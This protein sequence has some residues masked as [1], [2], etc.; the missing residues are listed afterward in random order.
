MPT[1]PQG[2]S[3]IPPDRGA[4]VSEYREVSEG[5]TLEADIAEVLAKE[6]GDGAQTP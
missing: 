2:A 1:H 3:I 4:R 5:L 6:A